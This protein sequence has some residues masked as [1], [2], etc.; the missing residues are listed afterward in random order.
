M[1]SGQAA[2]GP[3]QHSHVSMKAGPIFDYGD[4]PDFRTKQTKW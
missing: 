3:S 2:P 4:V 1:M